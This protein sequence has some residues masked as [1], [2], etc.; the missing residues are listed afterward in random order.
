V[1]GVGEQD[2]YRDTAFEDG[3]RM[4]EAAMSASRAESSS[5]GS[6]RESALARARELFFAYD[7]SG[8]YMSRDGSEVEYR[9]CE[10]P[11]ALEAQWRDELTADKIAKLAEPGNWR[12]LNYMCHHNN[13]GFLREVAHAEPLGELWQRI[14]YLELAL[15]YIES[16]KGHYPRGEIRAAL[17]TVQ[18]RA[19]ALDFAAV[20]AAEL[21]GREEMLRGRVR[22]LTAT[23]TLLLSRTRVIRRQL[24]RLGWVAKTF[25]ARREVKD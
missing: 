11:P 1:N 14:S 15:E 9:E 20:P 21:E 16:C 25:S 22:K 23:T 3:R 4:A 13:T 18:A 5:A 2:S 24:S 8:F 7:G 6:E 12:S 10:V 19:A 17:K